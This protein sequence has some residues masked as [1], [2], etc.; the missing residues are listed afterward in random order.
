MKS[1]IVRLFVLTLS[2]AGFSAAS[3]TAQ[4]ST[5]KVS[6][7]PVSVVGSQTLCPPSDPSCCGLD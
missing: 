4:A 7:A 2:V 3:V 6:S 5:V 1:N